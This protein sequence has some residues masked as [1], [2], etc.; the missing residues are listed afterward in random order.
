M[1]SIESVSGERRQFTIHPAVIK[2]LINEQ[3]GSLSKAF[4]ELV[5]NAVD[6]GATSVCIAADPKEG[7]FQISD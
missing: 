4:A 5:M 7:T 6:A 3:A 2:T 1:S